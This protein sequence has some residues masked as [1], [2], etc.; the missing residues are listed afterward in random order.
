[1][2]ARTIDNP[3]GA[4]G[5]TGGDAFSLYVEGQ[6]AT[7]AGIAAKRVVSVGTDGRF[8]VAAT[9]AD[10]KRCVG[11]SVSTFPEASGGVN[12]SGKV[13]VAGV[14]RGVPY[15][16]TVN[17]GDALTRSSVSAG[18]VMAQAA[19]NASHGAFVGV[20]IN[21]DAANSVCDVWVKKF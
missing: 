17:A 18:Y 6:A 12:G 1:V 2:P 16:G 7:T 13:A 20:A 4:F 14:V 19:T 15:T 8:N 21:V 10:Q 11:I 9:N 5:Q 3:R